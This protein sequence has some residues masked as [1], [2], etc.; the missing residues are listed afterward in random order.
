MGATP[1]V[2]AIGGGF[3]RIVGT[4]SLTLGIMFVGGG[5]LR[6]AGDTRT[7]MLWNLA[8]HWLLG[9]PF[10]YTL[11]FMWGV[12]VSGLWVG[13]STGLIVVGLV[14]LVAWTRRVRALAG[15]R[16]AARAEAGG[17]A[18]FV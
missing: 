12:G 6:G 8:G 5:T 4:F 2:N 11:C 1:A 9:L 14:L 7:P 13:L 17:G 3:L 18:F 10:G 15:A 16:M